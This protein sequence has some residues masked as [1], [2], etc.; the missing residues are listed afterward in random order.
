MPLGQIAA[1]MGRRG[2]CAEWAEMGCEP[3]L[4]CPVPSL[5]G[6]RAPR[7][8]RSSQPPPKVTTSCHMCAQLRSRVRLFATPWAVVHQAPLSVGFPRQEHWSGLPF[9]SLQDLPDP[10]IK[11]TSPVNSLP[12]EAPGKPITR[13]AVLRSL[14]PPG[15]PAMP[16]SQ[17][18]YEQ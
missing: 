5:R 7:H 4:L 15:H 14:P 1:V 2:V 12:T 16:S 13:Q 11:S 9:P 17:L 3:R 18:S 6:A 8:H 10:G